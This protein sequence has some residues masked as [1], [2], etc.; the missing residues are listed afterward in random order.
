MPLPPRRTTDAHGARCL[1][2]LPRRTTD[3]H[4]ARCFCLPPSRCCCLIVMSN[5]ASGSEHLATT[6]NAGLHL[7]LEKCRMYLDQ[8]MPL[9]EQPRRT[10][11]LV[12]EHDASAWNGARCCCWP[13]EGGGCMDAMPDGVR[14]F[15]SLIKTAQGSSGRARCSGRAELSSMRML[16]L[17]PCAGRYCLARSRCCLP[18]SGMPLHD[19]WRLL[20]EQDAADNRRAGGYCLTAMPKSA[21]PSENLTTT[22]QR[23][24]GRAMCSRNAGLPSMSSDTRK[25]PGRMLAQARSNSKRMCW[26]V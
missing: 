11:L 7:V 20:R 13:R 25:P 26:Q 24:S 16:P 8:I 6:V 5:S 4:G 12:A 23:T 2:L 19:R 17:A 22:A 14:P 9:A 15:E 1:P 3:A 21:S 18:P 10:L